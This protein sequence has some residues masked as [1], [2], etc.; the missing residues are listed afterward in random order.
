MGKVNKRKW[1]E[2]E[3]DRA[4]HNLV[5]RY[6]QLQ[7]VPVCSP[8]DPELDELLNDGSVMVFAQN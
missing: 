3:L 5:L 4:I 2:E 1:T 6:C 7:E 8:L